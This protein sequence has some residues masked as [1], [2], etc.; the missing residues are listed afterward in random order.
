M[1]EYRTFRNADP[2][3]ILQLWNRS[4][5]T[6][7][8]GRPNGCDSFETSVFS[9]PYFDPKGL[10]LA[11][12]GD[13]LVGMCHVGFGCD[14]AQQGIDRSM[15][16][17]CVLLVDPDFRHR[18]IGS[19]LLRC[20][21]AYLRESGS[22]VQYAG[23]LHPLN[24]FYFGLYGGSEMP[25]ILESDVE[26][27]RFVG[28]HG[29]VDAD[30]CLVYQMLLD[31]LSPL[32]DLR[33]PLLRR[34]VELTVDG[35]MPPMLSRW[36]ACTMGPLTILRYEMVDRATREPIGSALAWEMDSFGRAWRLPSAGLT[37]VE[38]V[39]SRRRQGYGRLLLHSIL[40]H[41]QAQRIGLIEVQTMQRNNAACGLYETLGFA[42][43]DR[44]HVYRLDPR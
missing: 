11:F 30:C 32:S 4:A 1:I 26:M 24:P 36:Q 7:G 37:N 25:G 16:V 31:E 23:G 38:I 3:R 44:G 22:G 35:N 28:R 13:L 2:P 8:F 9:K 41:L 39:E 17:L 15:G 29:Y 43:V 14:E 42:Q 20:G 5:E 6:R 18:G 40:K 27:T 33:T 21:Q 34:Q 12:D 10:L 19:E